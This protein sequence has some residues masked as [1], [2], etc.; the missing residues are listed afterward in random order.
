MMNSDTCGAGPFNIGNP[1]EI[2]I[3]ELA[4]HIL[5]ITGSKSKLIEKP[6]PSDDPMRRKPDISKVKT[7]LGWEP[8]MKLEIGLK[9]TI[10]YFDA[11]LKETKVAA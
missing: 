1:H 4:T 9:R 5:D 11:L 8:N 7:A 3:R 6:L 2:T 10:E